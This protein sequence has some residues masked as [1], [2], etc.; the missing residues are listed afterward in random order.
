MAFYADSTSANSTAWVTWNDQWQT[1]ATVSYTMDTSATNDTT[2][3]TWT[4]TPTTGTY[5]TTDVTW[6]QWTTIEDGAA[7]ITYGTYGPQLSEE[8]IAAE[9]QRIQD[10]A[11]A[12]MAER[13]EAVKKA[14]ALLHSLLDEK[15]REQLERQRFFDFVSQTGRRMR[16]KAH[17]YS[18]NIDELGPDGKR[19]R[20]LCAHPRSYEL[21]LEDHLAAQLLALRHNEE[22]FF[23]HA[24]IS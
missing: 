16:I 2:W 12:R 7:T 5:T 13:V 22:E 9:R 17:S 21:P 6:A 24:N 20:T 1:S 4:Q 15:Q 3:Y 19:I 23:R 14:K 11:N 8:D 10:A 18:R